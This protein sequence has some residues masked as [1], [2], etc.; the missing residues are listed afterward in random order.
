MAAIRSDDFEQGVNDPAHSTNRYQQ[1]VAGLRK[2]DKAKRAWI[3][4][5]GG[6]SFEYIDD[7]ENL[8]D[9]QD[10]R[11]L[12]AHETESSLARLLLSRRYK[13]TY[14]RKYYARA[15]RWVYDM[16][17][18]DAAKVESN[19]EVRTEEELERKF[20]LVEAME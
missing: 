17:I 7:L 4:D 15:F 16:D 18:E 8:K 13:D 5:T 3:K 2:D 6:L 19:P 1:Y 11:N 12:T 14:K 9:Y 20:A 10:K